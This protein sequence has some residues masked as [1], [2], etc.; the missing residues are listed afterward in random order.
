MRIKIS[1]LTEGCI[2]E[3]DIQIRKDR[4]IALKKT[5]V[6]SRLIEVLSAFLVKELNVEKYMADGKL[7]T[8]K[9][10]IDIGYAE[11]SFKEVSFH[12]SY[13]EAVHE[14]KK[15][16]QGWQAGATVDVPAVRKIF[17]PILEKALSAENEIFSLHC[18]S[19]K[20]DYFYHHAIA[21][22]IISG[23]IAKKLSYD[24]GDIV[25]VGLAGCLSDVGMA[26]VPIRILKKN[27]SLSYEEFKDVKQHP[28]KG[29]QML[30][31][32]TGLKKEVKLAILQHHERLDG[33]GYPNNSQSDKIHPYSRIVAV[34]DVYHAMT[35]DRI[36][37]PK[38]SPFQVLEM[39][40]HDEF[41]KYDL[42]ILQTLR[43]GAINISIGSKVKLSNGEIGEV[44]FMSSRYPTRPI[45][46][47]NQ[48]GVL[49]HL[50]KERN[51]YILE[52]LSV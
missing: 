5:V 8:P 32:S 20:E 17:V 27:D 29:Y 1:D 31:K 35:S 12:T 42:H 11:E 41:G 38:R 24:L 4:P 36:Y 37:R 16:F 9:E 45:I 2:L 33:S 43:K 44:M 52:E 10:M 30:Q 14:F 6:D 7:F 23:Y 39:L 28:I 13:K 48:S 21:V 18:L 46:R 19:T 49:I 25:Q 26:K 50:E 3:R 40:M 51:L 34:A 15:L 47:L 22:G